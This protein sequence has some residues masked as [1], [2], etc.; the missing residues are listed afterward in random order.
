MEK[1]IMPFQNK[2]WLSSSTMHG[3]ELEYVKQAY[4]TNWISTMGENINEAERLACEKVGGKYAV[5]LSA[6]TAASTELSCKRAP[7]PINCRSKRVMK[8]KKKLKR[9]ILDK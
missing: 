3:Q 1:Q 7:K 6:G 9:I 8:Q 5:A 2:V 4:E